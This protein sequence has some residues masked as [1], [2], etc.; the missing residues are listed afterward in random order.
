MLVILA[1]EAGVSHSC[2]SI[3]NNQ[4]GLMPNRNK[5]ATNKRLAASKSPFIGTS[6]EISP[7]LSIEI[8]AA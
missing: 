7:Y 1:T 3:V 4:C 8:Y 5:S 2:V 6:C